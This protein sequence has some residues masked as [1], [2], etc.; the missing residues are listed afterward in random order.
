MNATF[1]RFLWVALA[2]TALRIIYLFINHRELDVEEAQYWTWSQHLAL[3]YH[4][5][6]PMISWVIDFSTWIFGNSEWAIR[7]FSPI[8]Y[9][10]SAL[11]LY[12]CGKILYDDTIGFWSGLT[13][14]LLPGVTYSAAIIS[15]DPIL[16]LFW[17]L[18][19]YAFINA[20]KFKKM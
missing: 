5:K 14:L 13:V 4:S 10:F 16:L 11:L 7:F 12:G 1:K 6:P 8:T 3:G 9:L 18:A 19:F 2:I 20:C 15:T 17:C